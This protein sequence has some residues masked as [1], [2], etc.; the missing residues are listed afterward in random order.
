M[1]IG[2]AR[3]TES[4]KD[5]QVTRLTCVC[6]EGMEDSVYKNSFLLDR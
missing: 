4:Q 2:Q 1:E 3:E 5:S 6:A